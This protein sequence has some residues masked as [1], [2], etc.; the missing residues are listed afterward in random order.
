MV[1]WATAPAPLV[2]PVV[3]DVV[4]GIDE[5]A[6]LVWAVEQVV[7]GRTLATPPP[8]PGPVPP[9][10][11]PAPRRFSY[12]AMSQVPEHWH[13]YLLDEPAAGPRRYIQGRAADLSGPEPVL[14][15]EPVSDLLWDPKAPPEGPVHQLDPAS[16]PAEGLRVQRRAILARATTGAPVFWTQRRRQVLETPPTFALRFDS[17]Q[18]DPT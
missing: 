1:V 17:L 6:N 9:S 12:L 13:P 5:D 4:V 3:D 7:A 8:P 14:L 2:G 15:P 18:E 10:D 16:I 11:P